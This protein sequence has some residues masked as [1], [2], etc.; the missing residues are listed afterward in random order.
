MPWICTRRPANRVSMIAIASRVMPTRR[1]G[2]PRR[3]VSQRGRRGGLR[4]A[5][6]GRGR[7]GGGGGPAGG[8][9]GGGGGGARGGGG[10]GGGAGGSS[11]AQ[12]PGVLRRSGLPGNAAV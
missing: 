5:W 7:R 8:G 12:C 3:A 2:S 9:G 4:E 11:V 1:P 10:G 6:D